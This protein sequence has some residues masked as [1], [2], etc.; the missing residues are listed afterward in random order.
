MTSCVNFARKLGRKNFQPQRFHEDEL[1]KQKISDKSQ[2]FLIHPL[3]LNQHF[4][5]FNLD[6]LH[7]KR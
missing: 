1:D 3:H 4:H 7:V 5:V 6:G 2:T